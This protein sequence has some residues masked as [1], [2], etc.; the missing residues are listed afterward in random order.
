MKL[1]AIGFLL[2]LLG[3]CGVTSPSAPAGISTTPSPPSAT[4]SL[5]PSL[6]L[7]NGTTLTVTL[8]VNGQRVG[9]VPPGSP[10]PRIDVF[11]LPPVPWVVQARSPSG[12]VLVSMQVQPG[13]GEANTSK[14]Q[15]A[16][17]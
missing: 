17:L 14:A 5:S 9:D 13:D 4:P 10:L 1:V 11:D 3:G 2:V 7:T 16:D 15:L 12:R 6:H 8:V